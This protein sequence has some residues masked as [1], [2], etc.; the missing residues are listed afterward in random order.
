MRMPE[1]VQALALE[2]AWEL[3]LADRTCHGQRVRYVPLHGGRSCG[4]CESARYSEWIHDPAAVVSEYGEQ[5]GATAR[6]MVRFP[7]DSRAG[8]RL[9]A[10]ERRNSR[11]AAGFRDEPVDQFQ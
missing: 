6:V 1:L 9:D 5:R 4:R 7:D 11:R 10:L 3:Q 8:V 2:A